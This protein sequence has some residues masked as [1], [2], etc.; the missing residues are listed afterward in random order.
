[1]GEEEAAKGSATL[2]DLDSGAQETVALT[3]LGERLAQLA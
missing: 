2:R 3:D 1:L